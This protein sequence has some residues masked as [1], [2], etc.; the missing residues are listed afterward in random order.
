MAG[1]SMDIAVTGDGKIEVVLRVAVA[2]LGT[3]EP[4]AVG[5]LAVDTVGIA[6]DKYDYVAVVAVVVAAVVVVVVAAV[7]V[8][9]VV[10]AA[11]VEQV[12]VDTEAAVQNIAPTS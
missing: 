4:G 7:V 5:R 11:V 9:A 1:V 10:A 8:V 6:V 3:E 12:L 2:W